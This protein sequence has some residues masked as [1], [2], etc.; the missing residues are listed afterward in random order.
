MCQEPTSPPYAHHTRTG[1]RPLRFT[2]AIR[3]TSS[4]DR[5]DQRSHVIPADAGISTSGERTEYVHLDGEGDLQL[6]RGMW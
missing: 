1:C 2:V 6:A 5:R 4:D 3:P